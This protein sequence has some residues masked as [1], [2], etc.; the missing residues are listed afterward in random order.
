MKKIRLL[1]LLHF[2]LS[3]FNSA[4]AQY[5]NIPDVNFRIWLTQLYPGCM[6]GSQLDTTCTEIINED[7]VLVGGL[8]LTNLSGIEH[9]DSLKFLKC[10]QNLLS[11]LPNLPKGLIELQ[12]EENQ[13]TSLPTLP[14]TLK[15]LICNNNVISSL[16]TLPSNLEVLQCAFNQL[17]T[18]PTLPT[19]LIELY[20]E[21]NQLIQLPMLPNSLYTIVCASNQLTSLP[22]LPTNL[23]QL[24]CNNNSITSFPS[25]PNNLSYLYCQHNQ[26]SSLPALPMNLILLSLSYNTV[27]VIPA[28]PNGLVY[29]DCTHNQISTL[30]V[31]PNS[32]LNLACS[33]NQISSI[34]TLPTS[35]QSLICVNNLLIVL[36]SL[37]STLISLRCGSNQITY[38]PQLPNTLSYL[39]CQN[40]LVSSIPE[41]PNLM[42]EFR[43]QYNPNLSCVHNLPVVN[44]TAYG[45]IFGNPLLTCVPNQTN[46]SLGLPMCV[47]NDS[48]YN[49][50]N[51]QGV[52]IV[53][54]VYTNLDTNCTFDA[55]DLR[56]ENIPVKLYDAQNN[57]VALS[58]TS[59]GVFSFTALQPDS[60]HVV[61]DEVNLPIAMDCN[62]SSQLNLQLDSVNQTIYHADFPVV[63]ESAYDIK[64]QN[65]HHNGYVFPGQVHQLYTDLNSNQN[66]YNLSCDSS[67]YFGEVSIKVTGPVTFLAPAAGALTP[68]ISGNTFSYNINDFTTIHPTSFG[69]Q[70]ITDTT[71]QSGQ[72]VCVFVEINPN[73]TDADTLNNTYNYCYQVINSLDPNMK[74]VYP[75]NVLPGYQD[76]FTYTIHFQN[77]GTAPAFNIRLRD[78]LDTELDINTFEFMNASHA[79]TT[80]LNGH[81]LTIRF[82]NIMLPDSTSN[83]DASMGYY[84]YRIKPF[85]NQLDGT[86]ITNTAYIYF[87]Y[88]AA[89]VTNTTENHFDITTDISNIQSQHTSWMMYPNPSKGIFNVSNGAAAK[90]VDV[91]N[92]MGERILS[93]R[94]CKSIDLTEY[95]KGIYIA[96]INGETMCKLMKE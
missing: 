57:L 34:Q 76:W 41:V 55:S 14:N 66:L 94:N 46:Y 3:I 1:I 24:V 28:L 19:N 86:Q 75:T 8:S 32:L 72:T 29:L 52:N 38:L 22:T 74:E 36:P 64:V 21:A 88:N 92:L 44:F 69:L 18:L 6:S 81:V 15:R 47:D 85:P 11:S 65:I 42:E 87:D 56:I 54:N 4:T 96:K 7:S 30:P 90:Q 16:Q 33:D 89:V 68:S 48:V 67:I 77:T 93:Q 23:F 51:C 79:S 13:L 62:Q 39:D 26:L 43:I 10:G 5:V 95:P 45:E 12:C 17:T 73:P 70:F 2:T 60:F 53:G 20:C 25:L 35:L 71:A 83:H 40:T 78:T 80:Q 58:Y 63:C 27:S 82:N 84:Q 59:N 50:Y 9:F 91:Y 49:P 61:I 37:P 31:L